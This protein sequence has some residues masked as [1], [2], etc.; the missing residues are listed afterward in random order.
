LDSIIGK[1][2]KEAGDDVCKIVLSDHG[3][4]PAPT[5][6]INAY[7]L[8]RKIGET[9]FSRAQL[10]SYVKEKVLGKIGIS[11]KNDTT[12]IIDVKRS[13]VLLEPLYANFLGININTKD[14]AGNEAVSSDNEFNTL[15]SKIINVLK[16]MTDSIS[17]EALV[18]KVYIRESLFHGKFADI[19]PDIVV[20]FPYN[21]KVGFSPFKKT[22]VR[23]E[24]DPIRT[25][26][27]RREGIFIGSGPQ[28]RS[29][30]IEKEL[31]I[32]DITPT[33]LYLT[34][35]PIPESYDGR[36][37]QELF[38]DKY[39]TKRPPEYYDDSKGSEKACTE[40]EGYDSETEY[41]QAK[42][43][44]ENLGYM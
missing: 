37:V 38:S 7:S 21:T 1:L 33:I 28:I 13:R 10:F 18:D 2:S 6:K 19:A 30:S 40:K 41:G 3:F 42:A 5:E 39:L 32:Q 23:V 25:G 9:S 31:L 36:L 29:G 43:L 22:L 24:K 34:G 14:G 4:G 8:L 17:G 35:C 44:L 12:D 11:K 20:Q 26:E 15:R 16:N 27:H